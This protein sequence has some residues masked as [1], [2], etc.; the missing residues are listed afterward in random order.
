MYIVRVWINRKRETITEYLEFA[1]LENAVNYA[2]WKASELRHQ[3]DVEFDVM[4]FESTN[5]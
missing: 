4:I 5:Y 3:H 2:D 1:D